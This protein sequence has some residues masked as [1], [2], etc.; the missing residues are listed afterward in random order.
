MKGIVFTEFLDFVDEQSSL[1][2]TERLIEMS[3]LPSGGQ[4]TA[5]GTYDSAEMATLVSN[6]SSLTGTPVPELFRGFGQA[7]FERLA[8]TNPKFLEGVGSTMEF[9]P[10]VQDVVHVEVRKLYPDAE[11]PTFDCNMSAPGVMR[12]SYRSPRELDDLA[13]GLI[14]GCIAHFGDDLDLTK[15]PGRQDLHE[16]I[17]TL[18]AR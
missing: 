9:L 5:V 12:M 6:L 18:S 7:L 17:F 2:T 1:E 3:D 14:L 13:E 4:Y 11:L 16:T 10:R 8:S 15:D